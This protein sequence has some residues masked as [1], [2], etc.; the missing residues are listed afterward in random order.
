MLLAVLLLPCLLVAAPVPPKVD[1]SIGK[2]PRYAGKPRYALLLIG[3]EQKRVWLV[4]DGDVLYADT[5]GD[6]DLSDEKPIRGER[7]RV[8]RHEEVWDRVAFEVVLPGKLGLHYESYDDPKV[9]DF[10]FL[11]TDVTQPPFSRV[12]IHQGA[13]GDASGDFRFTEKREECPVFR[14]L[15]P[16]T[17]RPLGAKKFPRGG[18]ED[19]TVRVGTHGLGK[20]SF[21]SLEYDRVPDEVDPKAEIVFPAKTPGG[22]PVKLTVSLKQRC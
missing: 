14:F 11:F 18:E 12:T 19:L 8:T 20:G 15:G 9:N 16:L 13:S 10:L 4:Q 7:A 3:E 17:M 22:E 5:N 21:V 2:E 1:R 6:G